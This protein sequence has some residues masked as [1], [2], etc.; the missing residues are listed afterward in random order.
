MGIEDL[1]DFGKTNPVACTGKESCLE[2]L[3]G[4][5]YPF[6]YRRSGEAELARSRFKVLL[7]RSAITAAIISTVTRGTR[8]KPSA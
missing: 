5:L 2:E 3:I 1:S 6:V 7:L 4:D 8:M